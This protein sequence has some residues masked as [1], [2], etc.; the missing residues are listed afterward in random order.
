MD[1]LFNP[2]GPYFTQTQLFEQDRKRSLK[3]KHRKKS[4]HHQG[5]F[6]DKI[7]PDIYKND[8]DDDKNYGI[9]SLFED[10]GEKEVRISEFMK[11]K[12]KKNT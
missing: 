2:Q 1:K 5:N 3:R 6:L 8:F 11:N 12:K 9:A 4:L 7:D 10:P